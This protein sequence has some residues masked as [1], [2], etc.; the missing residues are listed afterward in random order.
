MRWKVSQPAKH[1][2]WTMEQL[3]RVN[4][5]HERHHVEKVYG[6]QATV[7]REAHRHSKKKKEEGAA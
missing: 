5:E 1:P 3:Q 6:E 2:V 7:S 4:V